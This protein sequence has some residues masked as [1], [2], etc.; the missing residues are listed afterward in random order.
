[1]SNSCCYLLLQV[2]AAV[3]HILLLYVQSSAPDDGR[4]ECPKHVEYFKID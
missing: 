1:M 2:A 4:K 3:F